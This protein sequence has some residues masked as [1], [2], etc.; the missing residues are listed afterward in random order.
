MSPY[1]FRVIRLGWRYVIRVELTGSDAISYLHTFATTD[2]Q[3]FWFKRNAVKRA[4]VFADM[5]KK[6]SL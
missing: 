3:T 2:L 6:V 1:R 4:E 5:F